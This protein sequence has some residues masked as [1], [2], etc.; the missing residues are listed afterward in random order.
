[1]LALVGSMGGL[2]CASTIAQSPAARDRGDVPEQLRPGFGDAERHTWWPLTP[3]ELAALRDVDQARKGEMHAL[4]SLAILA[5]GDTR[6]AASY[7]SYF[8]R[9]DR[10]VAEV[11]PMMDA[12]PDD[13]HRGYELNRAMHRLFFTGPRTELGSYDFYQSRVAGIFKTGRYNCLSSAML[14][15]VLARGFGL[16]VR[17]A[18]VPTH[19]F[20]EMG[21][22]GGKIIEIETTSDTGFD[23][24]HDQRFY[25]ENAANW[26]GQR[27]L[28]PVTLEE[29]QHRTILEPYQLM[30]LGMRNAHQGQTDADRY[31]LYEVAAIV[32][33]DD[34]DTQR[35]RMKIYA[36]EAHDLFDLKAWRTMAKL[37]DTV[38]PAV[39]ELASRSKDTET[40]Q[41]TSWASWYH[42]YSLI[43]V[44][45]ADEAMALT[46]EG[47]TH[48]D[49]RWPDGET[50]RNNYVSVINDR[51]CDLIAKEDFTTALRVFADHRDACRA[52]KV[53][54]GNVGIVYTNWSITRENAGDWPAARQLLQTC[55][56]DLPGDVHCQD[57][58]KEL[59]GR[60]RF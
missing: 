26:S 45:R 6:D 49:S 51:M 19:V 22:P 34:V 1:L 24:V 28:R 59:E 16:P 41:L 57:A 36:A 46:G 13:W 3:P 40:L 27:G 11:K 10:F 33:P 8:Q 44:G 25:A 21:D 5:G 12:A 37:F 52:D 47:L 38:R 29:Y 30:A 23:W 32:D 58:L 56:T 60:H 54:G 17:A 43:I 18:A 48:L 20:V 4:L 2:G 9:V 53:C 14:F 39:S 15:V 50:L 31:R 35:R 55:L 7:A 42:A